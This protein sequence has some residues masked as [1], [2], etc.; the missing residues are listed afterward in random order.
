MKGTIRVRRTKDGKAR[1]ACQVFAGIDPRTGKK[2][3]LTATA[4]SERQ[5]H[6]VLHRLI[7]QVEGGLVSRERATLSQLIDAWLEAAG[8]PGEQTRRVM[9]GYIKKHIT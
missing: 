2:R 8:P 4:S 7:T 6:Q 1:Y 3:Y 9:V 5:A